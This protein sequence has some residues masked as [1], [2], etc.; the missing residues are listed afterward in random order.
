MKDSSAKLRF[1]FSASSTL[2][3]AFSFNWTMI[4]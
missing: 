3:L 1:P 2:R 4:Y